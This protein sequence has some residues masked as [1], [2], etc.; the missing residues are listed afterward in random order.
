MS[1]SFVVY[2]KYDMQ[3]VWSQGISQTAKGDVWDS[4]AEL[5]KERPDLFAATPTRVRG[6]VRRAPVVDTPDTPAD[7][8]EQAPP[9]SE[10]ARVVDKTA[11]ASKRGG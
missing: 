4:E 10:S 9:P 2:A 8:G 7:Q 3:V 5:V 6:E 11:G 1:R